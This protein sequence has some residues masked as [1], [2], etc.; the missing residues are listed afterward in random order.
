MAFNKLEISSTFDHV[1]EVI[2]LTDAMCISEG[3][4]I[5]KRQPHIFKLNMIKMDQDAA[6]EQATN[7]HYN[8]LIKLELAGLVILFIIAV[9][10]RSI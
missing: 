1:N 3:R 9:I 6:V 4:K 7:V 8:K 2:E 10:F 5:S